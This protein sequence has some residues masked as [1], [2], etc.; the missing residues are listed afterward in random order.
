MFQSKVNK[1]NHPSVNFTKAIN[2]AMFICYM[3]KHFFC[4]FT[5]VHTGQIMVTSL[6]FS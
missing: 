6:T 3:I 2:G 5:F 4:H 1:K